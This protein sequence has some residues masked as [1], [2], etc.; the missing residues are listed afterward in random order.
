MEESCHLG[1]VLD[2]EAGVERAVRARVAAAWWLKWREAASLLV[3]R[4]FLPKN[5]AGL[6]QA[7]TRSVMLY[8]AET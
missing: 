6:Y 2:H 3:N 1:D 5:R 4:N 7:C 8:G